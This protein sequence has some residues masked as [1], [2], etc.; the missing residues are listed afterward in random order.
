MVEECVLMHQSHAEQL[1]HNT[2]THLVARLAQAVE[3]HF[4]VQ[5]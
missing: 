1:E 5:Y 3:G 2:K 4:Q